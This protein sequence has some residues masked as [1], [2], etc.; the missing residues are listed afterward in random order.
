MK[1]EEFDEKFD[2]GEDILSCLNI[3]E[4]MT[5]PQ[6]RISKEG[7][8]YFQMKKLTSSGNS[9]MSLSKITDLWMEL[10]AFLQSRPSTTLSGRS[11]SFALKYS[12]I[13]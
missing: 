3:G 9:I 1:A 11:S 2:N 8:P 12:E 10:N 13:A 7:E 4:N 6:E 5:L